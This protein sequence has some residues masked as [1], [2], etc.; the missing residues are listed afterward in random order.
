M[1]TGNPYTKYD[2]VEICVQ[3]IHIQNMIGVEICVGLHG[4]HIQNMIVWKYGNPF[5]ATGADSRCF[6]TGGR[7]WARWCTIPS[8]LDYGD[9]WGGGGGG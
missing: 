4:I 7:G 2:C 1:C 6:P 9:S 3:G 5:Q 8:A